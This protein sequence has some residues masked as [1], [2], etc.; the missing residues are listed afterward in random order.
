MKILRKR[1]LIWFIALITIIS[2]YIDL[3]RQNLNINVGPLKVPIKID[4]PEID[5]M[6]GSIPFKRDLEPKLGLDLQGGTHLVLTADMKD[7]KQEDREKAIESARSVIERR[8][9]FYGV[10]EPV[11]QTSKVGEEY[12][13]VVELAGVTDV[14]QAKDLVGQTARLEFRK[15]KDA[16]ESASVASTVE[17]TDSTGITGKDLKSADPAFGQ[18]GE[19]PQISFKMTPEGAT[20]LATVSKDLE[21]KKMPIFLDD[22]LLMD[23]VVREPIVNGEGRITGSFSTNDAKKIAIQLNAGA[24]PVPVKISTEKTVGASLGQDSVNRSL[25]AGLIGMSTVSVFMILFYGWF[26]VV[27]VVA[28]IIYTLINISLFKLIPVTLTLAGIAGFILSVGMAVDANILTFERIREERRN[29]QR[30]PIALEVGFKRAWT[31]IRDSNISSLI[32][33]AILYWF[34]TGT[35]R[36]FALT[37]AL[38]IITSMFTALVISRTILRAFRGT[39]A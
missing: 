12:R 8:V 20:K 21:G 15:L 17:N 19:G 37:L 35:V 38:G 34:G 32:T 25:L 26:G 31:S 18:G 24:L 30:L 2:V 4:H 14:N 5:W 3:P 39:R 22:K 13:I 33:A 7:I 28:L 16:S 6:I 10:S 27:A 36:G 23:P 9:N 1:F 11:V 29:G